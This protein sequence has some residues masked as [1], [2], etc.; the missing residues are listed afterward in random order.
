MNLNNIKENLIIEIEN[1]I[2]IIKK[3]YPNYIDVPNKIDL[4]KRVHI[5]DTNTIS[6][7]VR[8]K[9][10]YFPLDAFKVINKLKKIPGF[11][12]I[13]NHKTCSK[14]KIIINNNT[15]ISYIKHVFLKGLTPEEYYK[16]ILLHETMHFCGSGGRTA[17]REGITELKTRQLAKKYNLLTSYCGY[18]KEVKIAY[19]LEKMFGKNII[20]KISFSKNNKEIASILDEVSPNTTKFFLELEKIM[21][22]EFNNKYMKYKFPGIKGL[23]QKTIKYNSINYTKAYKLIEEYKKNSPK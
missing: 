21:E 11:G 23:F 17:L 16:E 6:L 2:E 15:Y 18:P 8:D 7:Y 5:E 14:D 22:E 10:F 1:L 3:E 4:V 19:Q 12:I 13:K 20:D 9:N